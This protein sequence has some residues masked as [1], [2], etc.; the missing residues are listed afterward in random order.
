M[1][2]LLYVKGEEIDIRRAINSILL[3]INQNQVLGDLGLDINA[4]DKHFLD[5][6]ISLIEEN[7]GVNL[8]YPYDVSIF[9]HLYMVLK[10]Y[11]EGRVNQLENQDAFEIGRASSRERRERA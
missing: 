8:Y 10:R 5:K 2:N 3:T 1:H 6:Q 4:S 7:L 9:T 11:R